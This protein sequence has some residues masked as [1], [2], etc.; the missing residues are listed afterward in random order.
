MGSVQYTLH[1]CLIRATAPAESRA[2]YGEERAP[3]NERTR[4]IRQVGETEEKR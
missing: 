2:P 1:E 4:P 3:T